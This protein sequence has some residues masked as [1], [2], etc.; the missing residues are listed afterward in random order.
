M[1]SP[2]SNRH[3]SP[4]PTNESFFIPLAADVLVSVIMDLRCR[5]KHTGSRREVA[6]VLLA[7]AHI[8]EAVGLLRIGPAKQNADESCIFPRPSTVA[9]ER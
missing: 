3:Q 4:V 8:D 6:Q 1:R 2:V 5:V 9:R 7:G